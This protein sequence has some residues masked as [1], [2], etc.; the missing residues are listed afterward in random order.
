[1]VFT[2][3]SQGHGGGTLKNIVSVASIN[4]Q[5]V[6]FISP[7]LPDSWI[8]TGSGRELQTHRGWGAQAQ[9]SRA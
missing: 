1:M 2:I 6:R 5:G 4:V 7:G 8:V 9:F 3:I